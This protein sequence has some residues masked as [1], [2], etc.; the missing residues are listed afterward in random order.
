MSFSTSS[1]KVKNSPVHTGFHGP[2]CQNLGASN[3]TKNMGGFLHKFP[4][5]DEVWLQLTSPSHYL[6]IKAK[7]VGTAPV[8]VVAVPSSTCTG[9]SAF[10][11]VMELEH[12]KPNPTK[13]SYR[14]FLIFSSG[15]KGLK[16]E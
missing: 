8:V 13:I 15:F 14:A 12:P 1:K 16:S 10:G 3:R 7:S 6:N 9:S 5:C 4:V 2:K 11:N